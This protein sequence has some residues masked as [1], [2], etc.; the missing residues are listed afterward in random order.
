MIS[1]RLTSALAVALVIAS[2][3]CTTGDDDSDSADPQQPST[4][5]STQPAPSTFEGR[6]VT[7]VAP[8]GWS[9]S[10]HDTV[11]G[12]V[13]AGPDLTLEV[14]A[15]PSVFFGELFVEVPTPATPEALAEFV[16]PSLGPIDDVGKGSVEIVD[17]DGERGAV[18]IP[19]S[20]PD[21]EGEVILFD[22]GD[23]AIAI[24]SARAEPGSYADVQPQVRSTAASF[25]L[26]VSTEELLAAL[27]PSSDPAG[28]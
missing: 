1:H 5:A 20:G 28:E 19:V 13:L 8:A 14:T 17:L 25:V 3:A 21:G 18:A 2:G 27:G 9:A 11:D 7:I 6:L 26:T 15:I 10:E 16:A 12:V 4:T 24:A 23:G 22:L